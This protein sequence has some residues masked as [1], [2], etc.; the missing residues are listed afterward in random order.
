MLSKKAV[1]LVLVL[2]FA[3][4]AFGEDIIG[5]LRKVKGSGRVLRHYEQVT[6][7]EGLG[8]MLGDRIITG[9]D[10]ALGVIFKD[11]TRISLGP[12][13]QIRIDSYIYNPKKNI[14]FLLLNKLQGTASY[15]S[16][17]IGKLAPDSVRIR[18]PRA[19]VGIR[20]TFLLVKA[21]AKK[22]LQAKDMFVL[23]PDPGTGKVGGIAVL[24]ETSTIRLS[25]AHESV[26]VA[27]DQ[28]PGQPVVLSQ[29]KIES[30]FQSA[31]QAIPAQSK[32]SPQRE[33]FPLA[34]RT[35]IVQDLAQNQGDNQQG[36]PH[37]NP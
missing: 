6:A 15:I 24:N 10:G 36:H 1:S 2:S 37:H 35:A 21:P 32:S 28:H 11:N 12:D 30:L 31:L 4:P 27:Q 22:S 5:R 19:I 16:G 34:F 14:F 18:T 7:Q 17:A 13:S 25:K 29:E 3:A 8:I 20:G 23:M 26:Q 9:P 33:D